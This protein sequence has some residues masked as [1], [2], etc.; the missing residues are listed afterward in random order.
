MA[1]F[2]MVDRMISISLMDGPPTVCVVVFYT[3][4]VKPGVKEG[5]IIEYARACWGEKR[6]FPILLA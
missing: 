6:L 2:V 5:D 3:N 4:T 1:D